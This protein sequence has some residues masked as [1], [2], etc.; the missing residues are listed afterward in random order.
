M[1]AKT[2][3]V[4]VPLSLQR[5]RWPAVDLN[6]EYRE[7][8]SVHL[9]TA[10]LLWTYRSICQQIIVAPQDSLDVNRRAR[11]GIGICRARCEHTERPVIFRGLCN[12][13]DRYFPDVMTTGLLSHF[14]QRS[15]LQIRH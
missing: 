12:T 14:K 8:E 1:F 13:I 11:G 6:R 7:C 10:F 3:R 9:I 2:F 5:K 4:L 15:A